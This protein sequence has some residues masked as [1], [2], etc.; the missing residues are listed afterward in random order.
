MLYVL[1]PKIQITSLFSFLI[2]CD[3]IKYDF[4]ESSLLKAVG[5]EQKERKKNENNVIRI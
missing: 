1:V 5:S 4:I 3:L 2:L